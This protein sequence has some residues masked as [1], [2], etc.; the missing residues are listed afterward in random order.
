MTVSLN[1][2]EALA[3]KAA[4]G[5][6]YP[7]GLAEEAGFATRWLC[8]RGFDGASALLALLNYFEHKALSDIAL[9]M[10]GRN[11]R[12]SGKVLCPLIT[13]SAFLDRIFEMPEPGSLTFISVQSPHLL[14]P[15]VARGSDVRKV[16]M[17]LRWAAG[18]A[19]VDKGA[20]SF[21]GKSI[22][23]PADVTLTIAGKMMAARPATSRAVPA[24]VC[25]MELNAF[26]ARI[27]APATALSRALGAGEKGA[28]SD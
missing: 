6:G 9:V 3:K 20:V 18:A 15:F 21:T 25:W 16:P 19:V 4:R 8:A 12:S 10:A 11:W 13:G 5:A 23:D 7:W 1:E 28:L 17:T 14:I 2:V 26:A 27:H 22:W 24:A